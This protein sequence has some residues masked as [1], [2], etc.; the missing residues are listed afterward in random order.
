M[1][2]YLEKIILN[3]DYNSNDEEVKKTEA[4]QKKEEEKNNLNNMKTK[5]SHL[6]YI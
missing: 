2:L 3:L 4:L 5:Y 6:I 1:H